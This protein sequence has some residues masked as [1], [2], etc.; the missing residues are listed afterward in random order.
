MLALSSADGVAVEG[1]RAAPGLP[2]G[3]V[4]PLGHG[5]ARRLGHG[6]GGAPQALPVQQAGNARA[7]RTRCPRPAQ[8]LKRVTGRAP[9]RARASSAV[10]CA[11]AERGLGLGPLHDGL[12]IISGYHPHTSTL[13]QSGTKER[14]ATC[15]RR[16]GPSPARSGRAGQLQ[17]LVR[18]LGGGRPEPGPGDGGRWREKAAPRGEL[19]RERRRP[20]LATLALPGGFQQVS[21]SLR[22]PATSPPRRLV[23]QSLPRHLART[24]VTDNA[25]A[26]GLS[27]AL[28]L[29]GRG[30]NSWCSRWT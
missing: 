26:D 21:F 23:R 19:R 18:G 8:G 15:P 14:A 4:G 9:A 17:D 27:E 11:R 6:D 13:D 30:G 12:T 10:G 16:G 7:S 1:R 25:T 5:P 2:V 3:V 22:E 24:S 28:T 20:A 29:V